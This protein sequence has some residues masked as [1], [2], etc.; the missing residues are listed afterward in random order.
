MDIQTIITLTVLLFA[1][2]TGSLMGFGFGLM[3]MPLLA[4][5]MDIKT[6]TPLVAITGT[7]FAASIFLGSWR[8]IDFRSVKKLIISALLG[9]P[10]GIFFLKGAGDSFMK[11]VLAVMIILFSAYSLFGRIRARMDAEW[12]A[13]G[14]GMLSGIIGAAYNMGGPPLIV[15]GSLK[16]WPPAEFRA[17]LF[18][19]F[20]PIS[21]LVVLSHSLAGLVT[22]KVIHLSAL[23]FPIIV[24]AVIAGGKLNSR[25]PTERYHRIVHI[26][27]LL[28]GLFLLAKVFL[29]FN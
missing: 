13:Y 28:F 29:N 19:L 14:L 6:V 18:S 5:S 3:A 10:I 21:L 25:I 16:K 12:P 27:L 4:L 17:N 11:T 9:I 2:F 15:Y 24:L 20:L 1:S 22:P 26:C 7:I 23:S 8:E